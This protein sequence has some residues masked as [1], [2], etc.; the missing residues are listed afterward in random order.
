V[1]IDPT[2]DEL[3][4]PTLARRIADCMTCRA[5]A[6]ATAEGYALELRN[7]LNLAARIRLDIGVHTLA[8]E[9]PSQALVLSKLPCGSVEAVLQPM[10][11]PK[12]LYWS[13]AGAKA[14][15]AQEEVPVLYAL[16]ELREETMHVVAGPVG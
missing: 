6:L 15:A 8:V 2:P 12:S 14:R 13:D 9:D 16:D 7:L 5:V 1:T 3:T 11:D 4:I 10:T